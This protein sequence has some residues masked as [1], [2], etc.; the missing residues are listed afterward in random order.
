MVRIISP[1]YA[2][3]DLGSNSFHMLIV[4]EVQGSVQTVAKIKRKVRLA[5]DLDEQFNLSDE[6]MQRGWDC[7]RIFAE[8]LQD[9][10]SEHIYIVAT[11]ALRYANNADVFI[12]KANAILGHAIA[13][14]SGEEEAYIIYQGVAHTTGGEEKR[15]VVDIG[16]ASTEIIVANNFDTKVLTSL[17]IGCITWLD[18]YFSERLLTAA[19]FERAI[20]AA[21]QLLIPVAKP[22]LSCGWDICVG[23][24]GTVQA[25]QEILLTQGVDETITLT[26]LHRLRQQVIE[27]A[28]LDKLVIE[29]LSCQ[30]TLVFPSGLAILIAFFDVFG[31]TS[32]T[33][34]GG[35]LREGLVY[36]M[37]KPLQKTNIQE[38]AVKSIQSRF[39][40]D[41]EQAN[42]V[43]I[44]AVKLLEQSGVDWVPE[45]IART[46]L[47][48][49]AKLHEI[50]LS[51]AYHH[52]GEHAAY[53]ITH[54]DLLGFTAS[55]KQFLCEILRI[56]RE[57]LPPLGAQ[58]ALPERS[59][60]RLLRLLRIA[61][62]VC[63]RRNKKA[64]PKL[65]LKVQG[66][67]V[68]LIF[69]DGWLGENA[70]M[71][72]ELSLEVQRQ[73]ERNWPLIIR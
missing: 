70:L 20:I 35:A 68:E 19:H 5:A 62:M 15:L 42:N 46:L 45:P 4:R 26:T 27:C 72:T 55:Q 2:A 63:H 57:Q 39:H 66:D 53:L 24:S 44:T 54:L 18:R 56:Y 69:P 41:C 59:A 14:I 11:A 21:K 22:Y 58:N 38:R 37:I 52:D 65:L 33:L 1:L 8:R 60:N 40:L 13:V 23:A 49:A 67:A 29:G 50:G 48:T 30:R 73:A 51:V 12:S 9:I 25:L 64:I 16:G 61:V 6:A 3:V 71:A 7:L 34:A 28:E 47:I 32:M 17:N 36:S 43:A 10:P 31:I